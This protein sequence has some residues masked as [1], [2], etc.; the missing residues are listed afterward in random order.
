MKRW[1]P[2]DISKLKNM[3]QKY[4]AAQI[5]EELGRGVAATMVKAHELKVSLRYRKPSA[6]EAAP[7]EAAAA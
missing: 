6:A 4:P 1:S 3:A 5:A 7:S 2:E